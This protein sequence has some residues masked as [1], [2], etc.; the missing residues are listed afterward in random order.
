MS[1]EIEAIDEEDAV[2]EYREVASIYMRML[3]LI[4]DFILSSRSPVVSGW[5]VAYAL[6]IDSLCQGQSMSNKAAE[7]G[8]TPQ[9]VSKRAK[10]FKE[11]SGLKESQYMYKAKR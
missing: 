6:G 1:D 2:N 4:L 8:V 5:G 10:E 7:L 11:V 3:V 9:A